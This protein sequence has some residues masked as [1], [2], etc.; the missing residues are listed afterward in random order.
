M[1]WAGCVSQSSQRPHRCGVNPVIL[2]CDAVGVHPFL[3]RSTVCRGKT[4]FDTSPLH[5]PGDYDVHPVSVSSDHCESIVLNNTIWPQS[6]Q[7][8][9]ITDTGY[10]GLFL[11]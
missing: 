5:N 3:V 10:E 4:C 6:S 2:F 8:K 11:P 1:V 9:N 7:V